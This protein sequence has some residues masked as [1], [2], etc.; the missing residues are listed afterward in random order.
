MKNILK[1]LLVLFVQNIY[2]QYPVLTTTSLAGDPTMDINF[3]KNGNYAIDTN[4]ERDQYVG[5]WR[6]QD[7]DILFELKMEKRD[8]FLF[9]IEYQGQVYYTYSDI[10]IFKYKLIKNGVLIYDNLNATIPNENYYSQA[11]KH[12]NYEY[13]YGGLLDFTR[14]VMGT[15]SIKRLQAS[16]PDKIYFNLSSGGY[17]LHNPKEFYNNPPDVKLFNIPTD[18]IEMV[19][20]N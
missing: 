3:S 5:L 6:Y 2:A 14:N 1:L 10:I 13:L 7:S 8:Q 11:T 20:V 19:R 16:N 12:G 4:N 17:S 15:V 9:K 18:G